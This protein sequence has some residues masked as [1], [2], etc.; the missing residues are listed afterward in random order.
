MTFKGVLARKGL[1]INFGDPITLDRRIKLNE[2]TEGK[3]N[4]QL[5]DAWKKIDNELDPDFEYIPK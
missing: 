4:A 5:E 1:E 2:E 3:L